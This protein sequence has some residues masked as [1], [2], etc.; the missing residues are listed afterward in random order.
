MDHKNNL[1]NPRSAAVEGT[2]W[3]LASSEICD[4]H[5]R[6]LYISLDQIGNGLFQVDRLPTPWIRSRSVQK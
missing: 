1:T 5:Y 6:H 4:L 2:I 3:R